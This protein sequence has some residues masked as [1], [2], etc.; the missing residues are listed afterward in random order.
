MGQN[1]L[2]YRLI[3]MDDV[4]GLADRSTD[5][6]N[7]LTVSRKFGFTCV[8][9]CHTIYPT[10][11]NWQMILS[12][13]KIFNIFPGSIQASSVIKILTSYCSRYTYKY[14]PLRDL[15]FSRLYFD[16]TSSNKKWC[17]T[18]DIRD[19]ND[20]GPARFRTQAANNKEQTCYYK[21]NTKDKTFNF[22]LALRKQTSTI[23]RIIFSIENLIDKT[24]KKKIF[25]LK[26]TTN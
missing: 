25:I 8:Y 9:I 15:W 26:S 18:I 4:S 23:D 7:F 6:A 20:L 21:Q 1:K 2:L 22:F 5:F 12:Q 14:I 24:N 17:L 10:R 13:T 11:N 3:V 16:I 19:V